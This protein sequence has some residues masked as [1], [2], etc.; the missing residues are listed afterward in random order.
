MK[1]FFSFQNSGSLHLNKGDSPLE[2]LNFQELNLIDS[3]CSTFIEQ[4]TE[5]PV[6]KLDALKHKKNKSLNKTNDSS[7]YHFIRTPEKDTSFDIFVDREKKFQMKSNENLEKLREML[8]VCE[9]IEL[10]KTPQIN[11]VK[12]LIY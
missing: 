1:N 5:M 7:F 3:P 10:T 12:S 6:N 11:K 4:E 8:D 2:Q 9:S